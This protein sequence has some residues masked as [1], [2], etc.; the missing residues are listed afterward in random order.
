M[1]TLSV[2][3]GAVTG[4]A[5]SSPAWGPILYRF[6]TGRASAR[7]EALKTTD[8][9]RLRFEEEMQRTID[10]LRT[11]LRAC[12]GQV[13]AATERAA[14]AEARS[15]GLKARFEDKLQTIGADTKETHRIVNSNNEALLEKIQRLEEALAESLKK[16]TGGK[17]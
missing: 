12:Q 7:D 5:A 11:E 6:L 10:G 14:A 4:L 9:I 16:N 1:D 3:V 15:E 2:I 17:P 13:L 8:G